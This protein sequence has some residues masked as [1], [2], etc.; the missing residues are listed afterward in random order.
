MCASSTQCT[1]ATLG[2]IAIVLLSTHYYPKVTLCK[3]RSQLC[4]TPISYYDENDFSSMLAIKAGLTIKNFA[5]QTH[6]EGNILKLLLT[7]HCFHDVLIYSMS[8]SANKHAVKVEMI[9]HVVQMS[10]FVR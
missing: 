7:R 1:N 3:H 8:V 4:R 10:L 5:K 2:L 9:H 6:K